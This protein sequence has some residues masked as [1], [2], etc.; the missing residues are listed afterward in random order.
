MVTDKEKRN[1]L[2]IVDDESANLK[3]LSHILGSEYAIYTATNGKSAI[4][5]AIEYQPDLI[6]LDILMPEMDGYQTLAGIKK[7]EEIK[8]IPVIFIS[9]LSSDK[10]EEKGLSLDAVDY[11]TKPFSAQI[12]KLRVRNQ[13]QLVRLH[14]DLKSAVKGAEAANRS[15]SI[16]LAKMSDEIRT[17]LSAILGFSEIQ[18]NKDSLAQ[19]TR[20]VFKTIFNS[21]NLLL[22]IINDILDSSMIEAG[23][24]EIIS[25]QYDFENMINDVIFFNLNKYEDKPVK[26]TLN[27]DEK[28]PSA[29][30]G[31]EIRVKQILNNLLSNAFKYTVA[32]EI[33]LSI[34]LD[35]SASALASAQAAANAGAGTSGG[36]V[37][38]VFRV[39]DTGQGMTGEQLERLFDD[40][41]RFNTENS[42]AAGETSLGMN[43]L[44]N[45]LNMMNGNILA[46]SKPGKG[47]VFTI[48]LPQGTSGAP[49]LG[50]E[51]ADRL[52][53]FRSIN[54]LKM[55][56][57]QI[58][59]EPM[60]SGKVLVVDDIDINLYVTREML[61]SYG[62][63]VDTAISGAEAIEKIRHNDYSIIF[64]DQIMPVMDGVETTLKIRKL[65]PKYENIP[66]IALTANAVFGVKDMFLANGFNDFTLK[67]LGMNE[68]NKIL[69]EWMGA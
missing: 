5:K 9:G 13:I 50:R 19:D 45:L 55:K 16:F 6:L 43:I 15:K 11:I 29:L 65:G 31:D 10:D 57:A 40:Y 18:L 2:L 63:Q 30:V 3:V 4:E 27:I 52:R 67:P 61:L 32:G 53:Q 14:R 8:G 60:P 37:M 41:S 42:H 26:F 21:G 24:L 20:D 54:E 56:R 23:K 39:R 22:G 38:L 69:K 36:F 68:L 48:R 64:M 62:L 12:V 58:V 59:R 66:I 7:R 17:P 46:E 1:S 25:G 34:T 47:S 51:A 33:E 44:K 49:A 28:I 35:S